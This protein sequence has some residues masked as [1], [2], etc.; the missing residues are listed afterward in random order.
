MGITNRYDRWAEYYDLYRP[1]LPTEIIE[2]IKN[3][4]H[5][6]DLVIDMGCGTGLSTYGLFDIAEQVVG[7][8]ASEAMLK[9]AKKKDTIHKKKTIFLN[10]PAENTS[11]AEGCADV[12]LCSQ[13]FQWMKKESFLKEVYRLLKEEGYFVVVD[14][15]WPPECQE[16]LK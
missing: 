12:V 7:V 14:Y 11:L 5:N 2:L 4:T 10:T 13:S 15:K 3:E 16:E 9:V 8:D 6:V 1:T